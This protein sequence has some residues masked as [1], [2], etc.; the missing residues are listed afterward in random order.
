MSTA[1]PASKSPPPAPSGSWV[2]R[3][4]ILSFLGVLLVVVLVGF[5]FLGWPLMKWRFHALF[6]SSIDEI[7]KSSKAVERLGEPISIPMLPLPSGRVFTEGDRGDARFD[8]SVVGSKE[9]AQVV[10][11]M[12]EVNGQWGFTQLDLEFPD[13]THLDLTQG[14]Q[15]QGGDNTPKFDPNAKQAD[16]KAPDLPVDI[17]LPDMPEMP[18]K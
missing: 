14:I 13:K 5:Y 7:H 11:V 16:V 1:Q 10:S 4:K 15:Q 6:V 12:R 17:K 3:H 9:K 2:A 18:K 8:F